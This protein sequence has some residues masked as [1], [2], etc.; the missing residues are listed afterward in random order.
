MQQQILVL[1]SVYVNYACTMHSNDIHSA[2]VNVFS[3]ITFQIS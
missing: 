3:V 2:N 1:R